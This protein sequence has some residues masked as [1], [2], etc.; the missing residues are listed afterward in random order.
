MYKKQ[1]IPESLFY[2]HNDRIGEIVI[3]S[4]LGSVVF[5]SEFPY[6]N[7]KFKPVSLKADSSLF[8]KESLFLH[9][10]GTHGWYNNISS[11][12]PLFIA[13][14]PSFKKKFKIETK[15]KNVDIYP[16]MCKLLGIE[17]GVNNGSLENIQSILVSIDFKYNSGSTF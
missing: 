4:K 9:Q 7:S 15:I 3:V 13:H 10:D 17:P 16:L 8:N 6:T 1:E 5:K 12:Y 11:M 2:K 14:G